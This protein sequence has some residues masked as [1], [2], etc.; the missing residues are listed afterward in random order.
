[1][2]TIYVVHHSVI[3]TKLRFETS[4]RKTFRE[5]LT[6]FKRC[7]TPKQCFVDRRERER[8]ISLIGIAQLE[9]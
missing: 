6:N 4:D 9:V 7:L 3:E 1:M 5:L 2:I 8:R